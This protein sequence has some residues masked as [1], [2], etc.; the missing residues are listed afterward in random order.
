VVR[1]D[2]GEEIASLKMTTA[3]NKPENLTELAQNTTLHGVR[4]LCQKNVLR[5]LFWIACILGAG[6]YCIVQLHDS[7][8]YFMTRPYSTVITTRKEEIIEFPA[9]TICNINT[10]HTGKYAREAKKRFP[11]TTNEEIDEDLFYVSRGILTSIY[12][13]NITW[14]NF[15]EPDQTRQKR[16]EFLLSNTTSLGLDIDD[17]LLPKQLFPCRWNNKFCGRENFETIPVM[18]YTQCFTFKSSE[19]KVDISGTDVG[20]RLRMTVGAEWY[21]PNSYEPFI[22]LKILV[23]PRNGYPHVESYGFFVQPGTHTSCA[24]RRREVGCTIT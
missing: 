7:V 1:G 19:S 18:R 15:V 17:L 13:S 8:A 24:I 4:F 2:S 5:K 21:L 22:G 11:N 10:I 6:G 16:I 12:G 3:E 23:H 20:L 14:N 9:V